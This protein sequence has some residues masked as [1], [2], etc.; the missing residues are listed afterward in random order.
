MGFSSIKMSELFVMLC[1]TFS[2]VQII[3]FRLTR[4]T[5]YRYKRFNNAIRSW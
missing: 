4:K 2:G 1:I 3:S 5:F